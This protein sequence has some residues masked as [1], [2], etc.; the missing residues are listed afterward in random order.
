[1]SRPTRHALI[2]RLGPGR[3]VRDHHHGATAAPR[4]RRRRLLP[5]LS[6]LLG[7]A[8]GLGV[9]LASWLWWLLLGSLPPLDGWRSVEGITDPV[10]I[11]RD[12]R[13]IPTLHASSRAD[14]AFATGFAHAQDRLFQMDLL[15]RHPAGEL[16]ELFGSPL[17]EEDRQARRHRFRA[18]AR[19]AVKRLPPRDRKLLQSYAAGVNAGR[20]S[21]GRLPWEYV[22]LGVEPAAWL[23]EDTALVGFGMYRMLQA[24][25]IDRE[26]AQ[27]LI[28]ELLPPSLARFLSP[29]GSSWDAPLLGP[30]LPASPLPG[31]DAVDLR[32]RPDDWL[33]PPAW[34]RRPRVRRGSNNWAVAGAHTAHGGAIVACDMHLGLMVPNLWY[35]AAL[36]WTG[37]D[38]ERHQVVGATLPGTP[39]V[40][41]GSNTHLA[42]GFTNVEA[43]T[44]DLVILETEPAHPGEYR[45]PAGWRPLEQHEEVI[46][47]NGGADVVLTVEDTIWGP[48]IDRDHHGRRRALRWVAHDPGAF[49]LKLMRLETARSLEEALTLAPR[50]G[51]PVQ[52]LVLADGRGRIA[53]TILGRLPRRVE[54][55]GRVPTS[56][57]DGKRGWDGWLPSRFYPR[58]L[59]P[60]G[61]RLWTANNRTVAEPYLSRLGL[62]TYDHGARAMQIRDDLLVLNRARERDML[63]VQLDDRALFLARW[64]RLLLDLLG[65]A[66]LDRNAARAAIRRQVVFG[67]GRAAV[68]SVGFRI[69]WQF[70]RNVTQVVLGSL[71]APCLRAD[72]HFDARDLDANTE[73]AVWKLVTSRPPHLLPPRNASWENLLLAAVDQ[74]GTAASGWR[75]VE[76]GL[77][78]YTWGAANTS[79]IRHPL[80]G[81]IGPLAGWLS[82][83]MPPDPL[84]GCPRAM[85]RIQGRSDG[86][87]QRMA[88]SPGREA[89]GYFHMPCGQ[90]GHPLSPH[91]RDGHDD[92]VRGRPTPFLPG[93]TQ[94][95]LE[96]WPVE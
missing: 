86:A 1:M 51:T 82:L 58:L 76:S 29:A 34:P 73:E 24:G 43:D 62:G 28:E 7:L 47:V 23:Q 22:L 60:H 19:A 14:L 25:C 31:A 65:P 95:V 96:L 45:T 11:E 52:N 70:R 35:R 67:G 93:P 90:S 15:R 84:P 9:L 44:A 26:R 33:P 38:G 69:V 21:L 63:D 3:P 56:W 94:H 41:V 10:R 89:E 40:V 74:V 8:L 48:V 66:N 16:A 92:W 61:G 72:K 20:R 42:W 80:S 57:A 37:S 2:H 88:V 78:S 27:G 6:T 53:W 49:D 18:R 32:R 4:H 79:R 36:V 5:P 39:A 46:R 17:L 64:H 91:Y 85:P 75:S 87:S 50:C 54:L 55:D 68:D 13:G 77:T 30:A 81:S 59:G 83:D 71:T 12:E